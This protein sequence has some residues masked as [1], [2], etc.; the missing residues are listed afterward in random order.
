MQEI[1]SWKITKKDTNKKL[2][3][4]LKEKLI[5]SNRESKKIIDKGLLKINGKIEKFSTVILKENQVVQ[6]DSS[7]KNVLEEK[8][9]IKT[10]IILYEDGYFLAIDKPLDFISSD[11]TIHKHFPKSY[12]LIHR[13]DKDTTGILL[14]AKSEKFKNE[15]I[16]LFKEKKVYKTYIALVDGVIKEDNIKIEANIKKIKSIDGQNLYG[17]SSDG[18]YALTYLKVLKRFNNL[19]LVQLNPITGR[20]HQLRVHMK[21][22][23]HPILGDYLYVKKF[24]Y[25]KYVKRL[26]LHSSKIEFIHPIT[27]KKIVIN[28]KAPETFEKF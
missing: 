25:P 8:K 10:F 27:L 12:T 3:T 16:K 13:L 18:D 15:M 7:W 21:F 9:I 23:H 26:M 22:L 24:Y 4:F 2:L 17:I 28:S 20:T 14:I 1:C 5:L 11:I 6:V 19:T